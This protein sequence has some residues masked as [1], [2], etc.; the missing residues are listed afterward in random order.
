[1]S[2]SSRE[3]YE[4]GLKLKHV[5]TCVFFSPVTQA[6]YFYDEAGLILYGPYDKETCEAELKRYVV[7]LNTGK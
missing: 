6:Y 1:M 2:S 7:Y 4:E 5:H 3:K